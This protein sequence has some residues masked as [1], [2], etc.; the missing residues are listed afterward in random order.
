MKSFS[1]YKASKDE[2]LEIQEQIDKNGFWEEKNEWRIFTVM[3]SRI[4]LIE[5]GDI[6][7]YETTVKCEQEIKIPAKTVERAIVFKKIY[8]DIQMELWT[9]LGWASWTTK[10][11]P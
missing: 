7:I 3:S 11:E 10:N 2:I 5:K 4:E 6:R 1:E 9:E 8:E